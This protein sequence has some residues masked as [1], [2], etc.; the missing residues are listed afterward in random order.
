MGKLKIIIE[1]AIEL[2][3]TVLGYKFLSYFFDIIDCFAFI[4][5]TISI[6]FIIYLNAE[7][8]IRAFKKEENNKEIFNT[9]YINYP[10][11]FE[12]AMLIENKIKVNAEET[13][14]NEWQSKASQTVNLIPQKTIF[15]SKYEN[16]IL[17]SNGHEY[18]EFQE[19]KNTNSTYLREILKKCK[20]VD[21]IENLKNGTLVKINDVKIEI[22]N[23]EEILQA[24]SIISGAFKDNIVDTY[25]NGQAFKINVN[26]LSNMVLKDYKYYLKCSKGEECF[27]INIPMKVEKEFENEYSI[28][29]L[30]IGTVNIIGIYRT[31][32]YNPKNNTTYAK[33]Q[34]LGNEQSQENDGIISSK[35]QHKDLQLKQK[36]SKGT[37]IDVIAIIQDISFKKE[38]EQGDGTVDEY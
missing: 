13:F 34:E 27:Y 22:L 10:K 25:S 38:D 4:Y 30:E 21:K 17:Q 18:K 24:N 1:I 16:E 11:V 26:S 2:L 36:I 6:L 23:N 35:K 3:L 37:Y 28:Y 8:I 29:D 14:K 9:Y 7:P 32:E 19:I 5:F 33:L 15:N 20:T 12:I 31:K